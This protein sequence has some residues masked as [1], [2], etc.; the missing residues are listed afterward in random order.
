MTQNQPLVTIGIPTYNRAKQLRRAIETAL[1]QNYSNIEVIVSDNASTDGTQSQYQL[2]CDSDPR[3]KYLQQEK[4][5]GP[6]ANFA[7]VLKAATGVYFM[8]LGDDDWI[9]AGYV[10]SCAR[11]L[12]SD[13]S[14]SLV[15]G[16]PQYYADGKKVHTGKYFSLS[17][18]S[19]WMR[20]I[21]YYAKVADNGMFYG[22]MR[23]AGI[24]EL[25]ISNV[26]GGDWLMIASVAFTGKVKTLTDVYVH[27]ELGGATASYRKIREILGLSGFGSMFP[28][29]S[30]AVNVWKD[31][32]VGNSFYSSRNR[33]ERF[34]AATLIS[35]M[36]MAKA[37]L[38]YSAAMLRRA[39][40][41]SKNCIYRQSGATE[42]QARREA[43]TGASASANELDKLP[44]QPEREQ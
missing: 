6:T 4:N 24:R 38:H 21:E 40:T 20:V 1:G 30:I 14:I 33:L 2:L 13:P 10:S 23:T 34:S 29:L 8:W 36:L 37:I 19:P 42:N 12:A 41:S 27:R 43:D 28:K 11:V 26:M 32:A 31:V 22:L 7:A 17:S 3:L 44:E 9:D 25:E 16:V 39:V 5:I 35:S 15:S 18:H